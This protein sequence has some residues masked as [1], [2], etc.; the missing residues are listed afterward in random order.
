MTATN[1]RLKPFKSGCGKSSRLP[2]ATRHAQEVNRRTYDHWRRLL[3]RACPQAKVQISLPPK[4]IGRMEVSRGFGAY[5]M[6]GAVAGLIV[7][8][9]SG[10]IPVAPTSDDDTSDSEDSAL[11]DSAR[12]EMIAL[13]SIGPQCFVPLLTSV[14]GAAAWATTGALTK[15]RIWNPSPETLC[16]CSEN[17]PRMAVSN[18]F[19]P[20]VLI[21]MGRPKDSHSLLA[22]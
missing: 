7:G 12:T 19:V 21:G 16:V 3:G 10:S 11:P 13:I 1:T 4:S 8:G 20:Q 2:L 17:C 15:R 6:E 9:T 18:W 14:A 22:D 5:A